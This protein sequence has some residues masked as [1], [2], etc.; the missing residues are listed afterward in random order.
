MLLMGHYA[1]HFQPLHNLCCDLALLKSIYNSI[2]QADFHLVSNY[3][4]LLIAFCF[5]PPLTLL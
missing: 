3:V 5:P 4:Y 1:K 2:S